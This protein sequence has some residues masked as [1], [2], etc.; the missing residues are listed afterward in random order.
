[1]API[2][3]VCI[4]SSIRDG[5]MGD[6]MKKLV[7]SQFN[8]VLGSKGHTLEVIDPADYDLPVLKLPLHFHRDPSQAPENLKQLN[9]IVMSADGYII[10]TAEYNR[11]LPPALTNLM[12]HLPPTSFEFKSSG[13]V[14]YSMSNQGGVMAVASARPFLSEFGCLPVKHFVAVDTVHK[15]VKEDGTTENTHICSSLKKLFNE[16]EWWARAAKALR[17]SEGK[18]NQK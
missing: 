13:V 15:E 14:S 7:E 10:V 5:R 6:R 12:D 9:E 1:M 3:L 18:P 16:V 2:K 11:S 17:E 8:E 4:L